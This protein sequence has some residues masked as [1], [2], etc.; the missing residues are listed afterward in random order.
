MAK[1]TEENVP[2]VQRLMSYWSES[3]RPLVSLAFIAPILLAYEGGMFLL[4]PQAM[5]NGADSWLRHVLEAMGFT[6]YFLLPLLTC[7]VLL[8]WH[9]LRQDTW[10][11]GWFVLYGMFVE[12]LAVGVALLLIAH[13]QISVLGQ[14]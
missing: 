13:W 6:Q 7:A 10:R 14:G 1:K 11:V 2:G 12:A 8:G 4:G 5:R 9:H 3:R